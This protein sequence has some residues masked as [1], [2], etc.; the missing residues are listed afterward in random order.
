MSVPIVFHYDDRIISWVVVVNYYQVCSQVLSVN[1]FFSKL[2][3]SPFDKQDILKSWVF[4]HYLFLLF[5]AAK[6]LIFGDSDFAND[7]LA[8]GDLSEVWKGVSDVLI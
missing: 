4:V 3:R 5:N 8:V 1:Y 7:S 2:A 6:L